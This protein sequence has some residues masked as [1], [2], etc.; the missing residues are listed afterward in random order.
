M[1]RDVE[2]AF[3]EG[4]LTGTLSAT[5]TWPEGDFRNI[6]FRPENLAPTLERI[7]RLRPVVPAGMS[8][9]EM[10]L[11]HILMHPAVST[12]IPGMRK[13][14]H[15]EQNIGASGKPLAESL[16][17]ELKRHRWDRTVDFE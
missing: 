5:S 16:M 10:A 6:Y 1:R 15:V 7:E 17:A 13:L 3:D 9:P 14:T 11:R 8:M 4:S 12:V 2:D